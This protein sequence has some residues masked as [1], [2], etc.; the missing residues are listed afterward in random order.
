[1][2]KEAKHPVRA[3]ETTLT[4]IEELNYL[5]S[6]GITEL[7]DRIGITKSAVH[8]HLST[9]QEHGYVKK[10]DNKY[11]IGLKFLDIGGNAKSRNELYRTA[12]STI[13]KLE[14][15][16]NAMFR[17]LTEDEGRGVILYQSERSRSVSE[18]SHI[19]QRPPLHSTAGGKAILAASPQ[20]RIERIVERY[21]IQAVTENTVTDRDELFGELERIRE[22]A[23]AT[24]EE[25]WLPGIRG[26][27]T[28]LTDENGTVLGAITV[29][30]PLGESDASL[31]K[32]QDQKELL[33]RI[34]ETIERNIEY[35]WYNPNKFI[36]MKHK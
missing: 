23:Y 10:S 25:E 2:P 33:Q 4:I 19:G 11:Q 24:E 14:I 21:G 5:G 15:Q 9:L 3:T 16:T 30:Y 27:G 22:R 1:M 20:Q 29:V 36:K 17:L 35:S 31:S 28:A 13:E 6:A 18:K 34:A 32:Q 8:N 12:K 26:V 7:A